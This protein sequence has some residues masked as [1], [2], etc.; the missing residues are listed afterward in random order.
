MGSLVG[1]GAAGEA[2]ACVPSAGAAVG[3]SMMLTP[4]EG[5]ASPAPAGSSTQADATKAVPSKSNFAARSMVG[6]T[7]R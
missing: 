4:R 7:V 1:A 2:G 3:A 5:L 6:L